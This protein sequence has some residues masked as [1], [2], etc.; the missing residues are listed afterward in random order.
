MPQ[1]D[2]LLVAN[3]KLVK[4]A[5]LRFAFVMKGPTEGRLLLTKKPPIPPKEIADA[6]K[7]LGGGQVLSGRCRWDE[8]NKEYL[9][10]LAKDPPPTLA[11]AVRTIIKKDTGQTVKVSCRAAADLAS[12]EA[13]VQGGPAPQVQVVSVTP[14]AGKAEVLKRL[15][16]LPKD[17]T[18]ALG[19]K[20]PDVARLHALFE[21]VKALVSSQDFP[22][23]GQVLDELEPLIARALAAPAPTAPPTGGRTVSPSPGLDK[24]ALV[25]RL[26]TLT[27]AFK[28]AVAS[29]SPDVPRMQALLTAVKHGLDS[30][31]FAAAEQAIAELEQLFARST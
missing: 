8:E 26:N 18:A 10:E 24:A 12:E 2:S 11:T 5:P 16:A 1:V 19:K 7:E 30:Q 14:A 25:K 28:A 21:Q 9:L 6:K 27:G 17:Y 23:A 31:D 22:K 3:L 13:G 15:S 29:K 4:T 20:G